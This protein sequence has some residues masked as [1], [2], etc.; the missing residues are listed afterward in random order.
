MA[1]SALPMPAT[2]RSQAQAGIM[3]CTADL[4]VVA[5]FAISHHAGSVSGVGGFWDRVT[6]GGVGGG[7]GV[8]QSWKLQGGW[9]WDRLAQL[10]P[11]ISRSEERPSKYQSL[12][13]H[14]L[15]DN[16]WIP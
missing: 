10:S 16:L 9:D 5:L 13:F 12:C 6:T 1:I 14:L 7:G 11:Q 15:S 8:Y 3:P 4:T 2:H